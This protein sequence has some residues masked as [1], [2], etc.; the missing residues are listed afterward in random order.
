M[1]KCRQMLLKN[2]PRSTPDRELVR[3]EVYEAFRAWQNVST[4]TFFEMKSV[5]GRDVDIAISFERGH[6]GDNY[7][8]KGPKDPVLA[9]AFPYY[10]YGGIS[11]DV[12]FNGDKT[13]H[14]GVAPERRKFEEVNFRSIA[15]HEFGHSLGLEHSPDK[16]SI[17]FAY[18]KN[19]REDPK[20]SSMDIYT[21]QTIYGPNTNKPRVDEP[22]P[23]P[24]T[25]TST[26]TVAPRIV[27]EVADEGNYEMVVPDPC[28][29]KV[30]AA[31]MIR[32]ELFMFQDA[33][34]WR[35][36]SGNLNGRPTRISSFY[37][38]LPYPVDAV[39]EVNDRVY[40]FVDKQA[41]IY[42]ERRKV[43][44][45]PLTAFGLP[46]LWTTSASPTNG[47]LETRSTTTFGLKTSTG[48][49]TQLQ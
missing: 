42:Q 7:I 5:T 9:H 8:F 30:G 24:V 45:K 32:S 17:M 49:W 35:F 14:V 39:V 27:N 22:V 34:F 18:Y 6:H 46:P 25:T 12:H 4:L 31:A 38:D 23:S 43:K 2:V 48:N 10:A 29:A 13:F 19:D 37:E 41:H 11:G 1:G 44:V 16:D 47:N 40:F 26:T 3:R 20:L 36:H 28:S 33:W 21:I 15:M